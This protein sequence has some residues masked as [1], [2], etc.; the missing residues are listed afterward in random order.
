V[1]SSGELLTNLSDARTALTIAR[2]VE[3]S[4][5]VESR[6][7]EKKGGDGGS[8]GRKV[9]SSTKVSTW[10]RGDHGTISRIDPKGG[11]ELEIDLH[12]VLRNG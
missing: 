6:S 7:K 10:V 2:P 8:G 1:S 12:F 3:G 11:G 4:V 9:P 5:M